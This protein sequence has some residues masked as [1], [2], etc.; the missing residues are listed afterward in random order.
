MLTKQELV[1]QVKAEVQ[2]IGGYEETKKNVEN[3][4]TAYGRVIE[5]ALL[6][7]EDVKIGDVGI[8]KTVDVGEKVGR[9]P[10]TGKAMKIPPHKTVRFRISKMLKEKMQ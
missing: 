1:L 6:K 7:G 4:I 2:T 10:Q 9:N 8:L 3:F 5:K